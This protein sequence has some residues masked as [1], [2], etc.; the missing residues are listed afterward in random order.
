MSLLRPLTRSAICMCSA[1]RA[2]CNPVHYPI[3]IPL[4][5][6]KWRTLLFLLINTFVVIVI[7]STIFFNNFWSFVHPSVPI[8]QKYFVFKTCLFKKSFKYLHFEMLTLC[9][10]MCIQ[11]WNLCYF[12]VWC[13][14]VWYLR[15]DF[16]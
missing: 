15:N 6:L 14:Y 3:Q 7:W 2:T 10:D 12:F 16:L 1:I 9:I 11:L 5:T 4:N 13:K 8:Q